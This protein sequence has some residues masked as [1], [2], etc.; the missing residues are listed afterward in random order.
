MLTK[1]KQRIQTLLASEVRVAHRIGLTPNAV[2]IIGFGLAFLAGV[3]YAFTTEHQPVF[4]LIA[5]LLTMISGFCD[6]LDGALARTY[7]QTS[8]FGGFLD[9]ILDRYADAFALAGIVISGASVLIDSTITLIVGLTALVSS[10]MVSYSRA[11]AEAT[12][13]K[14]ESVGVAERP[15]RILVLATASIAAFFWLPAL[16]IGILII[17]VLSTITV[18]QRMQHVYKNLKKTGK[19]TN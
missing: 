6:A 3:A 10:F 4:L 5:V 1:L 18:I 17:A 19:T 14:M 16:S 15:E 11:R 7:S 12:G 8:A 9:S 13:I 2:S